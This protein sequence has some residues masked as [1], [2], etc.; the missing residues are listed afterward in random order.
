MGTADDID[1]N[2]VTADGRTQPRRSFQGA[3]SYKFVGLIIQLRARLEENLNTLAHM[4]DSG[5]ADLLI[6]G[7]PILTMDP[8]GSRVD[9]VAVRDGRIMAT[10]PLDQVQQAVDSR[11][12]KLDL[13]G[14]TLMPGLVDPHMHSASVQMADWVDASPLANES[15]DD[16]FATLQNARPTSTGWV[17]AKMFD[18][19]I[20]KGHP[21]LDRD[22]LDK[23]CPDHPMMVSESNGHIA[24][25]N[26]AALRAA[27][28]DRDTKDPPQGRFVRDSDGELTGRVEELSAIGAFS[29]GIPALSQDELK[30]RHQE[31]FRHAASKGVTL[32]HDCA[33]G[34]MN[35][36]NDLDLL[37]SVITDDS[38]VRYR[39]MLMSTLYDTWMDLGLKPGFGD[40]MLRIDGMKAWSDG[41]NQAET[42]Y[43]RE[44]YLGSEDCG[45]LNYSPDELA[46]V[47]E[48]AH[49]DGWHIG[50]HSNGD[51]AI[52]VTLDAYEQTL[53]AHP[54]RDHRHRIEHCSVLHADQIT[55][56]V[57]L[58]LSPSFLIGHVRWWGTAF[59][60]RLLGTA[61][62][63]LYDPCASALAAG[64]RISLHSDWNVTP[65]EPL[66]Y[67]E[68][69]VTRIM[70]ES[71]D[72]MNGDERIG[73]E[74][75]L[76][77]VTIDAAWQCRADDITGSIEVGKYADLVVLDDD[78]TSVEPT[79]IGSINV[80]Q[81]LLGG[82]VRHGA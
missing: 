46:D 21:Q 20:T 66:R 79:N 62:A 17:I 69:A 32:L 39:G 50:V 36:G 16:V 78:P 37:R 4:T 82:V 8:A 40:D 75:A 49:R 68:D 60:D 27:G 33:I 35:G 59:R 18:P 48:R 53:R 6:T 1:S 44:P 43:Q 61:R 31:L 80:S 56:M 5:K 54:R 76:R 55:R 23:L 58:G 2:P 64:L 52:D 81:T 13:D 41:S 22:Q 19:S 30:A 3:R 34:A 9:A 14:R 71:G 24:H 38:P 57:E 70:N 51:A 45:S 29:E 67:V 10:G 73:V 72:V 74:A 15:A 12:E 42:G 26:S 47:I 63:N 11:T 25:V 77:A 28:V 7:G 65:L